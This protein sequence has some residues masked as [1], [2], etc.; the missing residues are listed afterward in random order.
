[1][2]CYDDMHQEEFENSREECKRKEREVYENCVK[3]L[4]RTGIGRDQACAL[5]KQYEVL[6][7]WIK[8]G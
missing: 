3:D 5:I 7:K 1:M 2:S 8:W 4:E 6:K